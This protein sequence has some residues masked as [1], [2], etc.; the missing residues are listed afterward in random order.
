MFFPEELKVLAQDVD[1]YK[2][3]YTSPDK[4]NSSSP[5]EQTFQHK[6]V[7]IVLY[8]IAPGSNHPH[9]DGFFPKTLDDR[10]L[11]STGWIFCRGGTTA[12]AF[13]P[14][15]P[16]VWIDEEKDWRLRSLDLKNGV[17]VEVASVH[18]V[19]DYE[20]FIHR[21]RTRRVPA[22]DLEHTLTASYT[23]LA[24]DT[25]TFTYDGPRK[26][27]GATVDLTK[28]RLYDGPFVSAAVGTGVIELR[29][30]DQVLLL[31]FQNGKISER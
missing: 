31:D 11:D 15:K 21:M 16:Y 19:G 7:I 1:R 28:T 29:Y 13:Y 25:L 8:N 4:W 17:I 24:G 2:I 30:G 23:S 12:V 3:V 6:N 10:S 26:L 14:L 27:N 22:P 20:N 9:I 18:T 5:Y